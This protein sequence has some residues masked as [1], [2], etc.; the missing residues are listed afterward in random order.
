MPRFIV[1][2]KS[3]QTRSANFK[4]NY[5]IITQIKPT[6][7]TVSILN[8]VFASTG[9][10]ICTNHVS[11]QK[12][13]FSDKNL[14]KLNTR[15]T[16]TFFIWDKWRRHSETNYSVF[17]EFGKKSSSKFICPKWWTLEYK[18]SAKPAWSWTKLYPSCI[19][20]KKGNS[21]NIEQFEVKI[22]VFLMLLQSGLWSAVLAATATNCLLSFAWRHYSRVQIRL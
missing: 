17:I 10:N 2:Q 6:P 7:H 8:F 13:H 16:D 3:T 18:I 12:H 20:I 21:Y 11:F 19:T 9:D 1:F 4:S 22:P 5:A 14:L 15:S